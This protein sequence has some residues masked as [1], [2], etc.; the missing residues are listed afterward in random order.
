M[1]ED[2]ATAE[3]GLLADSTVNQVPV[4]VGPESRGNNSN[5]RNTATLWNKKGAGL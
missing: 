4:C 1:E 3:D 5:N 2:L